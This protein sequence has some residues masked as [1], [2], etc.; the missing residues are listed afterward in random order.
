M[1]WGTGAQE[2]CVPLTSLLGWGW[3]ESRSGHSCLSFS[4]CTSSQADLRAV[5]NLQ[6]PRHIASIRRGKVTRPGSGRP[7]RCGQGS[8]LPGPGSLPRGTERPGRRRLHAWGFGPQPGSHHRP[9]IGPAA[10]SWSE[11]KWRLGWEPGVPQARPPPGRLS[12]R[13]SAFGPSAR[14]RSAL[15]ATA[16]AGG[17]GGAGAVRGDAA[18][19]VTHRRAPPPPPPRSG[20]GKRRKK[21]FFFF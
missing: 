9:V 21:T 20:S 11:Q 12:H 10:Q 4:I 7:G 15:S 3:F 5:C 8:E 1:D 16:G 14:A 2:S 18:G 19:G 17:G 6:R 13:G